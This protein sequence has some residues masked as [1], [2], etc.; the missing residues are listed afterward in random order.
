MAPS[1]A[2]PC[3][4]NAEDVSLENAVRLRHNAHG[5]SVAAG[6][7][8]VREAQ[9]LDHITS[10]VNR[11]WGE[12]ALDRLTAESTGGL[13]LLYGDDEHEFHA[14][15]LGTPKV[16]P[17]RSY[18]ELLRRAV[19]LDEDD[20]AA[21][22]VAMGEL[23]ASVPHLANDCG[24]HSGL[25]VSENAEARLL[26]YE[27]VEAALQ[28]DL[29]DEADARWWWGVPGQPLIRTNHDRDGAF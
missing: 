29:I 19:L 28:A 20:A 9:A 17:A 1:N 3:F 27:L 18:A 21:W 7:D 26:A 8:G 25:H 6:R 12:A 23:L 16:P 5:A 2:S 24:F 14:L 11:H 15:L 4:D 13:T 22:S 10:I